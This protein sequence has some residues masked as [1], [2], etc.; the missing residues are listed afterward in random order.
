MRHANAGME[1]CSLNGKLGSSSLQ[2][3]K[4]AVMIFKQQNMV[5][6]DLVGWFLGLFPCSPASN[7]TTK[8]DVEA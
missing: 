8:A 3:R 4:Q 5:N 6:I 2:H 1:Y 7:T